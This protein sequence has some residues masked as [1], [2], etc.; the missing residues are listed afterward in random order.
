VADQHA[1][2]SRDPADDDSMLGLMRQVLDKFLQGVDDCLP[3][4]VISYDRAANRATVQPLVKL[5]TTDNRQLSRAQIASV[6]VLRLG[7]GGM[8]L[9]FNLKPGDLGWIKAND[10][11]ISLVLQALAE[12]APNT[13]RKHSFADALFIPDAMRGVAIA[14][15]DAEHAV[16][17][18]IDGS[19]R[20]AVWADRVK[21][22]SGSISATVGPSA[23]TLANGVAGMT[24]T[25]AGT[26]FAGPV[27]IP[28]G[29]TINGIQFGTHTHSGVQP[30]GGNTGGPA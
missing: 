27:T 26:T 29:A 13:M 28:G 30:G 18:T 14:G 11:D 15:E 12:N 16:L 6:P 9:A 1:N 8:V 10:R 23:I 17:Q 19:V 5:L 2:P 21:I 4:R 24:M 20:V 7:G 3:A 22:S 25:S